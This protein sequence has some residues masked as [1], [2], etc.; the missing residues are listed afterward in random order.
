[1][2]RTRLAL[3]R[4]SLEL[5]RGEA[6]EVD[7]KRI[8]SGHAAVVLKLQLDL[9]IVAPDEPFAHR[10]GETD[11]GAAPG[12]I[13]AAGRQSARSDRFVCP[14]AEDCFVVHRLAPSVPLLP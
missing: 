6:A 13:G 10:A 7:V 1:M 2:A 12:P 5:P 8:Q 14:H 3:R 9:T 4:P 11:T